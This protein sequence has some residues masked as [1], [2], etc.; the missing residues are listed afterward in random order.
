MTNDLMPTS[1]VAL[2]ETTK[3]ERQ[4]FVLNIVDALETTDPLKVHLQVKCME[5]VIKQ[6]NANTVYK[7]SI[8][9]AAEKLGK[10]FEINA[11]KFEIKETGVKYDYSQCNDDEMATLLKEQEEL[12]AKIKAREAF[13]KT[14]PPKGMA[15]VMEGTGEVLT[16][17]PPAK[18]STTSVAVTLK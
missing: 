16:V 9:E 10:T 1:I 18:S 14:V 13:L 3:S 8:L 7:R 12:T 2:F 11:A 15:V 17:Y 5:D 4:S 6:L